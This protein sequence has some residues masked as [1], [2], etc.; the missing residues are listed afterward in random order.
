MARPKEPH[1][2]EIA[3]W[4][5]ASA[6]PRDTLPFYYSGHGGQLLE[7]HDKEQD[8]HSVCIYPI[9]FLQPAPL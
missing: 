4:L 8:D 3:K 9:D 2:C 5:V 1:C 6:C 7:V